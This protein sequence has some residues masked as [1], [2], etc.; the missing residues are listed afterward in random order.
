[1]TPSEWAEMWAAFGFD[2]ER[3]EAPYH[4]RSSTQLRSALRLWD[5]HT[6]QPGETIDAAIGE[7]LMLVQD[8]NGQTL[9][10]DLHPGVIRS[11][12]A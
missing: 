9:G 6:G 2:R 11:E 7:S 4:Y 5:G 12:Q 10:Y 8:S 3:P 1:M